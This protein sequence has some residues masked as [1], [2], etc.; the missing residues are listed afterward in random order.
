VKKSNSEA[1]RKFRSFPRK[2]ESSLFKLAAW[3][4]WTPA[5]AGVS[6]A[7]GIADFLHTLRRGGMTVEQVRVRASAAPLGGAPS[8]IAQFRIVR[9]L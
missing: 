3:Q 5:C 8:S 6:G 2:R 1:N 9:L 4:A 7:R